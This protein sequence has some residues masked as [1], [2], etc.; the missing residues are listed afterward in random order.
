MAVR[1]TNGH[2]TLSKRISG[3]TGLETAGADSDSS[4]PASL[5]ML[6][7]ACESS[8]DLTIRGD[9]PRTSAPLPT[10]SNRGRLAPMSEGTCDDSATL[11]L[12]PS[13]LLFAVV[14]V[15]DTSSAATTA[16]SAFCTDGSSAI[17]DAGDEDDDAAVILRLLPVAP[18][19]H[20]LLKLLTTLRTDW[21][22][23]AAG[24]VMAVR[25]SGRSSTVD[26]ILLDAIFFFFFAPK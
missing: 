3:C 22:I 12:L 24:F 1:R 15:V 20:C 4:N 5:T 16:P 18:R 21:P 17:H 9:Q 8:V 7:D 23:F 25:R 10:R 2:P 6:Y 19:P 13:T 26:V 11:N 14:A